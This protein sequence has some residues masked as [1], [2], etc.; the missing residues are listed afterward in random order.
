MEN[1]C[2]TKLTLSIKDTVPTRIEKFQASLGI[3]CLYLLQYGVYNMTGM[4]KTI[5]YTNFT[6]SLKA[7]KCFRAFNHIDKFAKFAYYIEVLLPYISQGSL[8]FTI[9]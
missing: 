6:S 7:S 8:F 5:A 9:L 3:D 2:S 4:Q 1:I